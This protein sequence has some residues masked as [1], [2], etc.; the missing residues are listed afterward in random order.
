MK[1]SSLFSTINFFIGTLLWHNFVLI[2]TLHLK[3][4]PNQ[5]NC[6]FYPVKVKIDLILSFNII[7]CYIVFIYKKAYH[8]CLLVVNQ[9]AC[10]N[11][12]KTRI[13]SPGPLSPLQCFCVRVIISINL[14]TP[15]RSVVGYILLF[16]VF[17]RQVRWL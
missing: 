3:F 16:S 6:L 11:L 15:F 8:D 13:Q 1:F 10:K 12:F 17:G 4:G 7:R 14:I 5:F 9:W 2:G